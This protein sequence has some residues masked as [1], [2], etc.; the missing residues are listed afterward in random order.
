[1]TASKL[2][3]TFT[4]ISEKVAEIQTTWWNCALWAIVLLIWTA[5]GPRLALLH[6]P[7][8]FI[9][10]GFNFPLNTLTTVMELFLAFL[11]GANTNRTS[12]ILEAHICRMERHIEN[13]EAYMRQIHE[14]VEEMN[15]E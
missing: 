13:M 8:W 14:D 12:K 3:E 6:L 7:A 5:M 15:D 1:M 2:D 11:V 10:P 9:S 4:L